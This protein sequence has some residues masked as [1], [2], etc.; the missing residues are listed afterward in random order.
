M[1]LIHEILYYLLTIFAFSLS[2]YGD[3]KIYHG[4]YTKTLIK[5]IK[6]NSQNINENTEYITTL[7][8]K[9]IARIVN[10]IMYSIAYTITFILLIALYYQAKVF[11]N[12]NLL[13]IVLT[14]IGLE[15]IYTL[16]Y[17]FKIPNVY[18]PNRPITKILLFFMIITSIFEYILLILMLIYPIL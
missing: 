8:G 2:I 11:E 18:F 1:H 4:I 17:I 10:T 5:D 13:H 16:L 6:K 12:P 7:F 3:Y 9:R 15:L 14:Y